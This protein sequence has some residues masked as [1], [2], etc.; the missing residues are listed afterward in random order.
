MYD[1]EKEMSSPLHDCSR[2]AKIAQ[3]MSFPSFPLPGRPRIL[4]SITRNDMYQ[5]SIHV[6]LLHVGKYTMFDQIFSGRTPDISDR[7]G[8]GRRLHNSITD[9]L[10]GTP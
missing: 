9:N 5:M 1:R 8:D 6:L 7:L 2:D 4:I 3:M 10:P